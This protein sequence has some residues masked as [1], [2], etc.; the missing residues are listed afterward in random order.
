MNKGIAI[1]QGNQVIFTEAL[2]N[3]WSQEMEYLVTVGSEP[4]WVKGK[5]LQDVRYY[6]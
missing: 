6:I 5:E 4:V 1:Y 2:F 3:P